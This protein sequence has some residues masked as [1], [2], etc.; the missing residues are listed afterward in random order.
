MS[1]GSVELV[2]GGSIPLVHCTMLPGEQLYLS[3]GEEIQRT[4]YAWHGREMPA[5]SA[6]SM[7]DIK[8]MVKEA[9]REL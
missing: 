6:I 3:T 8:A 5:Q 2:Q 1:V 7:Q 4:M 9:E